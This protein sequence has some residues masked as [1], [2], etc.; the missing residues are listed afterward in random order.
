M[1]RCIATSVH[2]PCRHLPRRNL[3]VYRYYEFHNNASYISRE[4]VLSRPV[5]SSCHKT[6]G[7]N[8]DKEGGLWGTDGAVKQ[9]AWTRMLRQALERPGIDSVVCT[10]L[11]RLCLSKIE[12][13]KWTRGCV[14]SSEHCSN[15]PAANPKVGWNASTEQRG[16]ATRP[17]ILRQHF[18]A[19]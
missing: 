3:L 7:N 12:K 14:G 4:Q 19:R 15:K 1:L 10:L 9:R 13:S 2:H 16:R 17:K 5:L 11:I 18:Q 8:E 6:W